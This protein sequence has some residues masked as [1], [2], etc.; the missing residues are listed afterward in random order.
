MNYIRMTFAFFGLFLLTACGGEDGEKYVGRWVQS[1]HDEIIQISK[2]DDTH[3][4]VDHYYPVWGSF[5]HE[6]LN[7]TLAEDGTLYIGQFGRAE[8]TNDKLFVDSIRYIS[9]PNGWMP[10]DG[11]PAS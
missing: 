2:V 4:T 11:R 8:M 3:F 9:V 6:A 10:R 7:A 5:E 1:N